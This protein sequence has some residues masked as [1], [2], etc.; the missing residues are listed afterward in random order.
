M[1]KKETTELY[2]LL[3]VKSRKGL[4]PLEWIWFKTNNKHPREK[5]DRILDDLWKGKF[6]E[7]ETWEIDEDGRELIPSLPDKNFVLTNEGKKKLRR[8]KVLY[9]M[10]RVCRFFVVLAKGLS[11]VITL[12][13]SLYGLIEL[14]GWCI[15]LIKSQQWL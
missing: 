9:L 8:E 1:K 15:R 10:N 4:S 5:E 11:C 14:C 6:V 2:I 7:E 12:A 3:K 13:A